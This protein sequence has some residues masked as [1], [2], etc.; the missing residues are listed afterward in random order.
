DSD[1]VEATWG[2][3]D[4]ELTSAEEPR[5]RRRRLLRLGVSAMRGQNRP[6]SA[7]VNPG[8][9]DHKRRLQRP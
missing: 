5:P 1:L 4:R 6:V 7:F 2:N 8:S 9:A 3:D